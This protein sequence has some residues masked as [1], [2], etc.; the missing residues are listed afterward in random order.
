MLIDINKI[1]VE[2]RIRKD[3]GDIE[4]LANSIKELGLLNPPVV[5]PEYILVAGERRLR[6]LKHL[7]YQQ[8]TVNIMTFEDYEQKLKAEIHENEH[9]KE[10]TF[11]ERLEWARKL[12]ELERVKAKERQGARTDLTDNIVQNSVRS[13]EIVAEKSGFGSRDTYSKAKFIGDNADPELIKQ[14]DEKQ[15]SVHAAFQNLKNQ[16][17]T[18]ENKVAELELREAEIKSKLER[19]LKQKQQDLENKK[20]QYDLLKER[21]R[22]L[23]EKIDL[24][25]KD[26]EKYNQLK[27]QIESLTKQKDDIGRQ[28]ESAVSLSGYIVEIE[29]FLKNKL[30]PIKYSRA[31]LEVKDNPTVIKNVNDIVECVEQWC[32]EIRNAIPNKNNR[33][34]IE[35]EEI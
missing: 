33:V 27:S 17:E 29:N 19:D 32:R 13:S 31:L 10:F 21:E 7:G 2:K 6:A 22:L 9:R 11:S 28:I 14:L 20:T 25:E 1:K 18:A 15:I 3:Y 23:N 16:K 30:A 24:Y 4:G 12:E 5:T 34:I 26:T 8:I 35:S